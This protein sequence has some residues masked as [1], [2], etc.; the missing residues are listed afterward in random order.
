MP[1][2][3]DSNKIKMT[4]SLL[5]LWDLI[6]NFSNSLSMCLHH[7]GVGSVQYRNE[8]WN[9]TIQTGLTPHFLS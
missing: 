4:Q 1:F 2:T 6:D 9:G 3:K 5:K 7:V 8:T